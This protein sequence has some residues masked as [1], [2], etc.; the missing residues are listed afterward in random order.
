[1]GFID[2]LASVGVA[3]AAM[4]RYFVPT[5]IVEFDLC[6]GSIGRLGKLTPFF[7]ASNGQANCSLNHGPHVK[8][9]AAL[10]RVAIGLLWLTLLSLALLIALAATEGGGLRLRGSA[11][12]LT[13][14]LDPLERQSAGVGCPSPEQGPHLCYRDL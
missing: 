2:P 10:K 5:L 7:P 12:S 4:P 14:T 9:P 6:A 3:K 8:V 1:M 13:I 11:S